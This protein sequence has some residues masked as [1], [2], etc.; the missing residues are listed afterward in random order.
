MKY[1]VFAFCWVL[2][3]NGAAQDQTPCPVAFDEIDEFDSLRVVGSEPVALGYMIPSLYE[4][5]DGPKLVE[6]AKAIMVYSENDSISGFFLNLI[7][8]EYQ[9]QPIEKGMTVKVLLQDST[10]IGFYNIPDEGYFDRD[11]NMRVYQ[12][13]CAIPLDYFY[14]ITYHKIAKIRIEYK[15]QNR[16]LVLSDAQAEALRKSLQCVGRAVGLYPIQP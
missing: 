4:L 16:T 2:A 12:H 8:P 13:T 15:K 3:M 6:E 14:R 1:I 9:L 11:I 5:A 10:V 7:V